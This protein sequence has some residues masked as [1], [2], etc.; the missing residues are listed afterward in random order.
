MFVIEWMIE[1]LF[2]TC[3]GWIGQIF[4][5]LITF[6]KVELEYGDSAT[7]TLGEWIGAGLLL[8]ALVVV[9]LFGCV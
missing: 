1:I 2:H 5:K 9:L 6:G 3:C 8:A 7:S 4:V